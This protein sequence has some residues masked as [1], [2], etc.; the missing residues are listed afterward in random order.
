MGQKF[1]ELSAVDQT[2]S[3]TTSTGIT[4]ENGKIAAYVAGGIISFLNSTK[5]KPELV[6]AHSGSAGKMANAPR[7]ARFPPNAR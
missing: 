3:G 6:E 1:S 5:G 4:R 2:I 7:R